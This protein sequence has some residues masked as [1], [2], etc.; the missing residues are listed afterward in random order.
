M[1]GGT[2]HERCV[3]YFNFIKQARLEARDF[4]VFGQILVFENQLILIKSS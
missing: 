1:T 3:S 4:K 2:V